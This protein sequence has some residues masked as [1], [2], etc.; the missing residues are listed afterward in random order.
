MDASTIKEFRRKFDLTQADLARICYVHAITVSKWECGK[1]VP[2][3]F[4]RQIIQYAYDYLDA[5][6]SRNIKNALDDHGPISALR[7]I[8]TQ[9]RDV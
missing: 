1:L 4:S 7:F 6:Q 3:L 5:S 2:N 8:L 9:G